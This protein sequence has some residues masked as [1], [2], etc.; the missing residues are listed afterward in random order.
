MSNDSEQLVG[1]QAVIPLRRLLP[2]LV[3]GPASWLGPYI[4]SVSLF[5]PAM[6]AMLDE[7]HKI[8]L[9]AT[10]ATAA[11]IVAAISN[12]VAGALSDRTR[13]RW[14]KRTPWLVIG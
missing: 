2:G 10:F 8:E 3:I 5:L 12:M 4:A 11:M 6:I 9:V 7:E 13:T 14:G 1:T